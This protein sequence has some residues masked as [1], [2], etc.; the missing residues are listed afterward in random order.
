M[1]VIGR[2]ER[3]TD[4]NHLIDFLGDEMEPAAMNS[5][6]RRQIGMSREVECGSLGSLMVMAIASERHNIVSVHTTVQSKFPSFA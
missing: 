3:L 6:T 5:Q 4:A 1:G 2:N